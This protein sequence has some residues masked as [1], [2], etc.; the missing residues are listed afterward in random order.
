MMVRNMLIRRQEGLIKLCIKN[1]AVFD[2]GDASTKK[3]RFTGRASAPYKDQAI[4]LVDFIHIML[5]QKWSSQEIRE[6][7]VSYC[8][9]G[10]LDT[11]DERELFLLFALK[12][13]IKLMSFLIVS[14]EFRFAFKE[15]NF[16]DIIENSAYD[17]GV[18]LYREYFLVLN[19]KVDKIVTLLV[20]AFTET[21]G[22]LEAKT[23]LLKRFIAKMNYDQAISF[24]EAIEKGVKNQSRG[25]LLIL[26]L[27]VIKSSCLLVEL[28]E[29]VR[30]NFGFLDRRIDEI[31]N[32]IVGIAKT[33]MDT[34]DN[35]EEMQYLL[36]EKDFDNRDSL[37]IIYDFQV[38][39]LLENP[40][41][42][43]IVNG[44]W[45][46]KFNVS[47]SI[48]SAS[49]VHNLLFNYDHCRYDMEK[50]LRF[51]RKKDTSQFGTHGFQ[52]QVW[53]YSAK[54]RYITFA[55]S[56][57]LNAVLMHWILLRQIS[58]SIY[59]KDNRVQIDS[60][61][62]ANRDLGSFDGDTAKI[63]ELEKAEWV[64][65]IYTFEYQ[66]MTITY[67]MYCS[68]M[69]TFQHIFE[70]VFAAKNKRVAKYVLFE[71][72]LDFWIMAMGMIYI[73][74]VYKVYRWNTFINTPGK[75]GEAE[76][77]W[78]NWNESTDTVPDQIF[79]II[80]DAT[81][82]IKAL[83]QLRLLPIVGPVYAIVR[84]LVGQ[85]LIFAIFFFLWQFIFSVIGN[86][87]FYDLASYATL[88]ESLLT[89][90][91]ASAGILNNEEMLQSREGAGWGYAFMLTYMLICFILIMN[92][93][94]GQLSSAYKKYVQ[95]REVLMLLETLSVREASEAD[96]KYSAAVSPVYPLSIAN[97]L[98]GT[99]ILSVKNPVHNTII[100]HFYFL[101]I[102]LVC[103]TIFVCYQVVILPFSYVKIVGHKF[104][105][106]IKNPQG[107]GAKSTS[108]R[109]AYAV[110]FAII[111]PAVLCLD[112]IVDI[113]WFLVH[114]YKT[115]LD[116]VARQKQEDRG[117]GIT[118]SINRRTFK[119]MLH[120]F[121]V[122]SGQEMQ[123]IALQSDVSKD[124]REY[125]GVDQGI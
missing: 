12:R 98:L 54:S 19:E 62:A 91:K 22:M 109:F 120:Y 25:N 33:Y 40:Y 106:M 78:G 44:I 94:V 39:E 81:Y 111:G 74:V 118:N 75:S 49:T 79:L 23:F 56:F 5:E 27:N 112:C 9:K 2:A 95:K 14:R 28:L 53:R 21:N 102:M 115:D 58:Q 107:T 68:W 41:A 88:S 1:N 43:K 8:Q 114:T 16:I 66:A 92:L 77:F 104:A 20:N 18:L 113:Y 6:T 55:V 84:M 42:Q 11:Q 82:V 71:N 123:Q 59:L 124:I 52:F 80:I 64:D 83:V 97:M 86:L 105:L 101:P 69:F 73:T 61:F 38:S 3:I 4:R 35:E 125:L 116:I 17:V 119:K 24:L 99:Y 96:E 37:N 50:K 87:L 29:M 121:E 76:T 46:S 72:I 70:A 100:L 34:V 93:I 67:L 7:I 36:L 108:D 48:F 57:V 85:L 122:Q 60:V 103:L 31:K 10:K 32:V 30:D 117:F 51:H 63:Y 13:K 47:S 90:F 45:E 89:I 15:E 65:L 26:S 110:Y